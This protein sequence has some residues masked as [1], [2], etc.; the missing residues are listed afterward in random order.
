[1]DINFITIVLKNGWQMEEAGFRTKAA[2]DTSIPV[3]F[4]DAMC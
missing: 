4:A 2:A 3:R 1:V